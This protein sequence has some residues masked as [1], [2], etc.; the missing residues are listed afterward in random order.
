MDYFDGIHLC[1]YSTYNCPPKLPTN[2]DTQSQSRTHVIH[3]LSYYSSL[4]I[5]KGIGHLVDCFDPD[6]I[7]FLVGK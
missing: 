2:F 5:S 3:S 7:K 1:V 6:I 4:H